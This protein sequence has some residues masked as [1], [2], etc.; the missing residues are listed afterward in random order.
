MLRT[1]EFL[2]IGADEIVLLAMLTLMVVAVWQA[3]SAEF[4]NE[5]LQKWLGPPSSLRT[6][7]WELGP[8]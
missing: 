7:L 6:A 8:V 4:G 2:A 3:C 5:P 1:A